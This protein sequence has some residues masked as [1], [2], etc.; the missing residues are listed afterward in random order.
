MM[1]FKYVE[2]IDDSQEPRAKSQEPRA[3]SQEPRAKS[4]EESTS[5][6]TKLLFWVPEMPGRI[7]SG[8]VAF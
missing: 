7:G 2:N 6:M 3:K 8:G 5:S 1:N 4:Q